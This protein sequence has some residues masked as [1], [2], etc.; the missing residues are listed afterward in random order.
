MVRMNTNNI[1]LEGYGKLPL[2]TYEAQIKSCEEKTSQKNNLCW[3]ICFE[4]VSK[5]FKGRKLYD[6][7]T[8]INNDGSQNEHGC[9]RLAL[10][11]KAMGFNVEQK[12]DWI[13]AEIIHK[14][15]N[16]EIDRY[17]ENQQGKEYPKIA[18]AG[19]SPIQLQHQQQQ[20]AQQSLPQQYPQPQAP[21]Q[22]PS[23]PQPQQYQQPPQQNNN[24]VNPQNIPF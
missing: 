10:L 5:D 18:Y 12:Q 9:R 2:G 3:N 16:V 14:F 22:Q 21:Q 1:D 11:Y 15:V 13:P 6:N 19:F 8:I 7:Y 23:V 24:F 17:E 20:P 4:I